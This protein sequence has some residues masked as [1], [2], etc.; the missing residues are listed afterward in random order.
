M[1]GVSAS[2]SLFPL[3]Q[4]SKYSFGLAILESALAPLSSNFS[5]SL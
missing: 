2:E 1:K 5:F 4:E 3:D